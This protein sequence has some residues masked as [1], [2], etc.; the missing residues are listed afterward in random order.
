MGSLGIVDSAVIGNPSEASCAI[1]VGNFGSLGSVR[2]L[3]NVRS[4]S[5]VR[6]TVIT[7]SLAN[8]NSLAAQLAGLTQVVQKEYV[9]HP[10]Y[11]SLAFISSHV[12]AGNPRR[13][14]AEL[15]YVASPAWVV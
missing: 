13:D 1:S 12:G 14:D 4:P 11:S 2:R 8:V 3:L 7:S 5:G 10:A 9:M 15:T 6:S